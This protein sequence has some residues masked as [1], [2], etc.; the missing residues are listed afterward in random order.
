LGDVLDAHGVT[1]DRLVTVLSEG[2]ASDKYQQLE[3]EASA[4]PVPDYKARHK[5]LETGLKLKGYLQGNQTVIDNRKLV[6][7]LPPE[8][9]P[10]PPEPDD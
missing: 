6:I 8:A 4:V 7:A 9:I 5:Y 3:P 10:P 2:L 1:N